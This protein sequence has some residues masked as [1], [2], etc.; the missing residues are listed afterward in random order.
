[1]QKTC[2]DY[3]GGPCLG[4]AD[5]EL[6]CHNCDTVLNEDNIDPSPCDDPQCETCQYC[7]HERC[8]NCGAHI[9]C[10]GCV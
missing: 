2:S 10:G 3:P 9:H 4:S 8:P 5:W 1:M 7:G 6:M